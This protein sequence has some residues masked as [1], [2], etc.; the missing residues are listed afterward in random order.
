MVTSQPSASIA[1]KFV[2]IELH[3]LPPLQSGSE[4]GFPLLFPEMRDNVLTEQTY[5]VHSLVVH[6]QAGIPVVP[7]AD[8]RQREM[9]IIDVQAGVATRPEAQRGNGAPTGGRRQFGDRV[10]ARS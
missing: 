10:V 9:P 8:R 4:E 3:Q 2:S 7:M 1:L 6:G 5:S